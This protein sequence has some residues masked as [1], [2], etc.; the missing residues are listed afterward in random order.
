MEAGHFCG[1]DIADA[2]EE[3]VGGCVFLEAVDS[4]EVVEVNVAPG[5][6]VFDGLFA[7]AVPADHGFFSII[8]GAGEHEVAMFTTGGEASGAGGFAGGLFFGGEDARRWRW[9][10]GRDVLGFYFLD[11]EFLAVGIDDFG[12]DDVLGRD[13]KA[14]RLRSGLCL[15]DG[16]F[17]NGVKELGG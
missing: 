15:D 14:R 8:N 6:V 5:G 10:Q 12:G 1:V 17:D 3:A 16:G 7:L 4:I 11:G 2:E 9:W 13:D